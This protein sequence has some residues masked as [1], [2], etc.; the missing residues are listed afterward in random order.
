MTRSNGRFRWVI[1]SLLFCATTVNYMDRQILGF[2]KNSL[3]FELRWTETDYATIVN[4]FQAAYAVGWLVAGRFIDLVGVRV[5]LAV[6]VMVWSLAAASHS[7]VRTVVGFCWAR[8]AL[9]LGEGGAWPGCMKVVSEWLPRR[10]RA[11]GTGLVNAGS[12]VGATITPL[13]IPLVLKFT[14]WPRAFLL[15]AALDLIWLAAWLLT[16]RSPE[17]HPRLS[18]EELAYIR[19]DPEPPQGKVS[20]GQLLRHR[21]AWAFAIPKT[22]TDPI[23]W[24]Y[25][26]WVPG[27]LAKTYSL[28]VSALAL[29]TVLIYIMADAGGVGG[30]WLSLRLIDRGRS[31]N[32]ARKIVMLGCA[33][34]VMPVFLVSRG[35]GLWPSVLLI[36]LAAAAH[37]GFS[38]NL[39]TV[40][41]DTVPRHAVSSLTGLGGMMATIA[42]MYIASLVGFLLDTTHSYAVPF[43]IASC[44]YLIA[45]GVLHGLLPHL[46]PMPVAAE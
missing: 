32:A 27:F 19:S 24:F 36:G 17:Q 41:T 4:S 13:F 44:S 20:W 3:M 6:A 1:L 33:I 23:W 11:I 12:A 5:G 2:L 46:E 29:P 18:P 45:L 26:F 35:V 7:L 16:Y 43:G 9:G 42:S 28:N 34:L 21:Q 10:E 22:L 14:T 31:V 37:Q 38:A 8:F 15:T 30:G 39:F 25:L 40:A